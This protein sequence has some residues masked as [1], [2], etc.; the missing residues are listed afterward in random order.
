MRIFTIVS[1]M[2]LAAAGFVTAATA[3]DYPNQPITL[4]VPY[5]AGGN[6]DVTTRILQAALGDSL[7]QP[8]V[9]ENRP[10]GGGLIAGKYVAQ[11][12]PDGHTLFV[13]SGGPIV[14][15]PLTREN[16]PYRWETAFDVVSSV[17]FGTNLML[18][19]SSFPAK[20]VKEFVAYAKAH[21]KEIRI[22]V[23]SRVSSNHFFGVLFT[24]A[25]GIEWTEIVFNG[26]APAVAAVVGEQIDA[27]FMQM[28]AAL[29][30]IRSG[31]LR[32]LAAL[33]DNR[34]ELLPDVPT[35]AEA[36]VPGVVGI[37][38]VGVFA[39]KGTP[40]EVIKFLDE[41]VQT[42]MAKPEAKKNLSG[43]GSEFPAMH[44]EEFHKFLLNENVKWTE[45][46]ALDKKNK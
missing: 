9:V 29:P 38:F 16:A 31:K 15:G 35:M 3:A 34:S 10:G 28:A 25:T 17:S 32:P 30:H 39:P 45:I 36:G 7:G 33:N 6:V 19:R 37:N 41:K 12:K 43:I 40:T 11:S 18:V 13:S 24:N 27:G 4:V 26:N 23:S 5:S 2:L 20:N 8:V 1:G 42:A 44:T 21:P 14:Y 22:G 46:I